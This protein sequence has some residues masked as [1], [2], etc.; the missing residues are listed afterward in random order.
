[1][2]KSYFAPA[3]RGKT[4]Q[5]N[6]IW[7]NKRYSC[8]FLVDWNICNCCYLLYFSFFLLFRNCF[9]NHTLV[10]GKRNLVKCFGAFSNNW[11]FAYSWLWTC[12]ADRQV[13]LLD[14]ITC[15]QHCWNKRIQCLWMFWIKK[16]IVFMYQFH[17]QKVYLLMMVPRMMMKTALKLMKLT[18]GENVT[19]VLVIRYFQV[20]GIYYIYNVFCYSFLF[21]LCAKSL[22]KL[23]TKLLN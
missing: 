2:C 16:S 9:Y 8:L 19:H 13:S 21:L 20:R 17:F 22:W 12:I 6:Y 14:F 23:K 18:I 10:I 11:L 1:M 15:M 4:W 3:K 7:W 5:R